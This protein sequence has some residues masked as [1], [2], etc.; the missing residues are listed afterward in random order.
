MNAVFYSG[1]SLRVA[2]A[3]SNFTCLV[4]DIEAGNKSVGECLEHEAKIVDVK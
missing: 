1:Q 2:T 3:L 4:Y